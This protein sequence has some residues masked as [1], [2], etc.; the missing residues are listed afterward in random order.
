MRLTRKLS[1]WH[2]ENIIDEVTVERITQYEKH[3]SKPMVLWAFGGMGVFAVIVGLVSI[4]AA[5][6]VHIPDWL[7][8]PVDLLLCLILAAALYLTCVKPHS[9]KENLWLKEVLVML[10]YGLVLAS[11]ALVGQTYQLGGEISGLLLLWTVV[12]VPLVLLAHGRFMAALWMVA[13]ATTYILNV[14][15]LYDFL[16]HKLD[17]DDHLLEAAMVSAYILMPLIFMLISRVPWLV[18]NRRPASE[19]ISRFS[20]ILIVII[21]F[22]LQFLWYGNGSS[23]L[24]DYVMLICSVV[25]LSV[26]IFIPQLYRH[27]SKDV[28]LAMRVVLVLVLALGVSAIWFSTKQEL[29]GAVTNLFYLCVLAWA[30]IKIKSKPLFNLFTAIICLRI[31]V[32]YFEVFGSMLETGLGLVV[33]GVLTL[34]ISWWWFK[35][36][37]RLALRL[38][39][40]GDPQDEE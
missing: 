32:I 14:D 13:V 31:L 29:A 30:S 10:Y 28:Q 9:H 38:A 12:T 1:E 23:N 22:C 3:N 39:V 34:L 27:E 5:N 36:S 18:L 24:S 15:V 33:G 35:R 4:I 6:W 25:T 2:R 40:T 20:W 26:V 21:G 11:M 16:R 37:N 8:L 19:V 17:L 7:K